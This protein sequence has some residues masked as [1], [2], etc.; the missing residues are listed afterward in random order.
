MVLGSGSQDTLLES[1]LSGDGSTDGKVG[2]AEERAH[3][4]KVAVVDDVDFLLGTGHKT[5]LS[6]GQD[7]FEDFL[8]LLRGGNLAG[9]DTLAP[10]KA[11]APIGAVPT[12][13]QSLVDVMETASSEAAQ[14]LD[15]GKILGLRHQ[16]LQRD[17]LAAWDATLRLDSI[18]KGDS[19]K[20]GGLSPG[21]SRKELPGC[22]LPE[23]TLSVHKGWAAAPSMFGRV[24]SLFP[25]DRSPAARV[26]KVSQWLQTL[27]VPQSA[28]RHQLVTFDFAT[29]SPDD[30]VRECRRQTVDAT[31]F[32]AVGKAV[33]CCI[34]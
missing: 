18:L 19:G 9:E 34:P 21:G 15:I 14:P 25:L 17:T 2:A 30:V 29:P 5:A 32:A 6:P 3:E 28:F 12:V 27:G 23:Q 24:V 7:D 20:C 4:D 1:L 8:A 11:V 33:F 26:V 16:P 31:V 22:M 10:P 13:P